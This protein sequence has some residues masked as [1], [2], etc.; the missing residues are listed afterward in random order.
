MKEKNFKF[1]ESFGKL[2]DKMTDKQAGEFIKALSG[3]VFGGKPL[4]SKDEYLKGVYLYAQNILETEMRDRENGKL[5]GA[6]IAEKRKNMTSK[7]T[8][9]ESSIMSQLIIVSSGEQSE[10]S[11]IAKNTKPAMSKSNCKAK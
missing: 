8:V 9:S 5:G 10:V 7:Q 6:I 4:D 3:F 1:R 11:D 2:V